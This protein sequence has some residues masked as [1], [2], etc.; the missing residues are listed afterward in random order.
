MLE[1][2]PL[3][4]T[5]AMFKYITDPAVS[6]TAFDITAATEVT[7]LT[8]LIDLTTGVIS[9]TTS[10]A[11]VMTTVTTVMATSITAIRTASDT[12]VDATAVEDSPATTGFMATADVGS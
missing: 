1:A 2:C 4:L 11:M 8:D 6:V 12:K 7:D 5:A 3:D 10:A 9:D